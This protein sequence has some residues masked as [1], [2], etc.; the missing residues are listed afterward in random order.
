M[1]TKRTS[2]CST[3][4]SPQ[5]FS[6]EPAHHRSWCTGSAAGVTGANRI[7]TVFVSVRTENARSKSPDP[8][9][10]LKFTVPPALVLMLDG[11]IDAE[12]ADTRAPISM[13]GSENTPMRTS[14]GTWNDC[15]GTG[16]DGAVALIETCESR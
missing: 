16:V 6:A 13:F 9:V 8:G 7:G 3:I 2:R 14:T 12:P 1:T 10:T 11:E 5:P 4:V 15:P